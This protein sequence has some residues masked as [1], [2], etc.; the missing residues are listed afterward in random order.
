MATNSELQTVGGAVADAPPPA[1]VLVIYAGGTIGMEAGERGLVPGR[2][3]A[4]R[5]SS[6]LAT[7][8]VERRSGL[9]DY[10][11]RESPT[12][13]DSSSAKPSDWSHIA[14]LIAAHYQ[15]YCGFVVLHGTDTLAWCASTL[16]FQLQGLTKPVI[17]TGS[18]RP[19]G[20]HASDALANLEAALTFAA[21][22]SLREVGLVFGGR[23]LRGCRTRKIYTHDTR[24]FE[25][26]NC[27]IL[28][29]IV[30][31]DAKL[32]V[33]RFLAN[34]GA[35]RFELVS[36]PETAS[37]VRLPLW[38]GMDPA[39]VARWLEMESVR[40]GVLECWGSGNLPEDAALIGVLAQAVGAGKTL[41]AVSQCPVGS[42]NVG[43]YASGETLNEIGVLSGDDMTTEA[44]FCKLLHLLSQ[45]LPL[46]EVRRRFLTP[47]SGE[48]STLS[49]APDRAPQAEDASTG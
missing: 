40:G 49:V 13:I 36:L 23:L 26:P 19:L 42:L 41:V 27:P 22:D 35:P 39:L 38:P 5:M 47:L 10:E 24:G 8:P 3:F 17:V 12:P 11:L 14:E 6:A 45:Q 48:R 25:S 1:Q 29:E 9:P 32:H 20:V 21:S 18:Q 44:A 31:G 28:G 16:T 15:D 7:L 2:D 34:Q 46:P 30:D 37:V 43:A 4:D 33:D